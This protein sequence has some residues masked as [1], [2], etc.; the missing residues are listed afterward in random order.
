[1]KPASLLR[2]SAD[3]EDLTA[4]ESI[5][6]S[7][8]RALQ[9]LLSKREA[10]VASA[11]PVVQ[12]HFTEWR[13]AQNPYGMLL[14]YRFGSRN[15]EIALHIPGYLVSQI[16]DIQYG[17]TGL[18]PAR[19]TFTA[20]EMKFVERLAAAL[21]PC[22]AKAV[23]HGTATTGQ[24]V[25]MQPDLLA[26]DWPKARDQTA[27]LNVFIEHSSIKAATIAC[28]MDI[29]TARQIGARSISSAEGSK[30]EQPGWQERMRSAA[31]NIPIPARA[32][33]TST[34]LPAAWLLNLA[35]GDILPVLLPAQMPLT[36]A[37]RHFARGTIGDANGRAAL[38]IE[39]IEGRHHE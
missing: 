2:I 9:N 20:T 29:A 12:S 33:L 26:F 32:I 36:I 17:G 19:G 21:Q 34:E 11:G 27:M 24:L 25:E 38:K 37:G 10:V 39:H 6:A 22:L 28:F 4:L 31:M 5:A 7:L 1:M 3:N 15:E 13:S 8:A 18:I 14:R 30:A 16:I 23:A 35:P